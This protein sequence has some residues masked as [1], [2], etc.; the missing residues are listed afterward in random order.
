M[1]VDDF[2]IFRTRHSPMEADAKLIV[3]TDAVLFRTV[4]PE[5][6]K[7]ISRWYPQVFQLSGDLQLTQFAADNRLDIGKPLDPM[8]AGQLSSVSVLERNNH[9]ESI[10]LCVINVKRDYRSAHPQPPAPD[11]PRSPTDGPE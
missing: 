11:L 4:T 10:T 8:A 9:V 2:H 1:V 6:F 3:D 5:R 7:S